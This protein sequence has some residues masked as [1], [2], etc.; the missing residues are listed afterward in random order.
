[1]FTIIQ[2][3]FLRKTK[4]F[5]SKSQIFLGSGIW[6][7]KNLRFSLRVSVVHGLLQPHMIIADEL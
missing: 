7:E 5:I 3:L 6:A 2:P 1:M 4:P